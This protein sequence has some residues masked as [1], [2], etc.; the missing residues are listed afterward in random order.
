MEYRNDGA[1]T[2]LSKGLVIGVDGSVGLSLSNNLITPASDT[3]ATDLYI[4]PKA[5]GKLYMG[6][7]ATSTVSLTGVCGQSTTTIPNMP[8]NSQAVSTMAAAG[9]STGDMIICCDP[10]DAVSTGVTLSRAYPS[11]ANE[12]TMVWNNCHASSIAAESTGIT[13]RW[14]YIDRT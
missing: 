8:A 2:H 11:A 4:G 12:I 5:G 9:I 10:R 6:G 13:V 1:G 14:M 7:A 3:T